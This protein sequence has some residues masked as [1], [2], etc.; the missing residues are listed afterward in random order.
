MSEDHYVDVISGSCPIEDRSADKLLE[1]YLLDCEDKPWDSRSELVMLSMESGAGFRMEGID[2]SM[3]CFQLVKR[4]SQDM[5][6]P[7]DF[8]VY[9]VETFYRTG[10]TLQEAQK[11]DRKEAKMVTVLSKDFYQVHHLDREK[12]EWEMISEGDDLFDITTN[13]GEFN[14]YFRMEMGL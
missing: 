7:C 14:T 11:S 13:S 6:F 12:G 4:M 3:E 1:A 2:F 10:G 8:I 5:V 9:Y